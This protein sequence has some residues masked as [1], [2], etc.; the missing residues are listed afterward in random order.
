MKV[1][2]FVPMKNCQSKIGPLLG[3]FQGEILEYLSE[4]LVVDNASTDKS[5]EEA[6]EALTQVSGVK[7]SLL[8][9]SRNYGLGGSHKIAFN[10]AREN[11]YDFLLVVHGDNTVDP[12]VFLPVLKKGFSSLDMVMSDRL[13]GDDSRVGYPLHRLLFNRILSRLASIITFTGIADFTGGP[14]NLYRVSSFLNQFENPLKNFSNQIEFSQHALLYG[15]YRRMKIHFEPIRFAETEV[16]PAGKLVTQFLKPILLILKFRFSPR[17]TVARDLKGSFFGHTYL[18]VK[19]DPA[20]PIIPS[21][22]KPKAS[23]QESAKLMDL[24]KTKEPAPVTV[25]TLPSVTGLEAVWIRMKLLPWHFTDNKLE[26]MITS[27]LKDLLPSRIIIDISGDEVVKN[28]QCYDFL[29]FCLDRGIEPQLITNAVGDVNLWRN[30]TKLVKNI[31]INYVP[32]TVQRSFFADLCREI[33]PMGNVSVNVVTHPEF[34]YHSVGLKK[35][36]ETAGCRSVLLQPYLLQPGESLPDDHMN[37]LL[38]QT[39]MV[40]TWFNDTVL[41]RHNVYPLGQ[42][43]KDPAR[44]NMALKYGFMD[45]TAKKIPKDKIRFFELEEDQTSGKLLNVLT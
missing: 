39:A 7:V 31:T 8:Q 43:L 23:N 18:K 33:G 4:I 32:G 22:P 13:S 24:N 25:H 1:L 15:I 6:K 28:K 29:T 38:E 21:S 36:I 20:A 35:I 27:L 44:Y 9:N 40:N 11:A 26:E 12:N 14:V 3:K 2:C 10:Y 41:R 34:F 45:M 42:T 16:K 30:Y 17:K 19:I 5:V 37:V